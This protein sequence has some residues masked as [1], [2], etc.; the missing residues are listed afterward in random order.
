MDAKFFKSRQRSHGVTNDDLAKAIGRDRTVI[1]K[2][3]SGTRRMRA[4]EAQKIA[5]KLDIPL[6]D[7]LIRAGIFEDDG[8]ETHRLLGQGDAAP[9]DFADKDRVCPAAAALGSDR[10]GADIWTVKTTAMSLGG[11]YPG[12]L[13]IVDANRAESLK[14]GDVVIAHNYDY[15][16]NTM[17]PI[18]RR[19]HGPVLYAEADPSLGIAPQVLDNARVA[20]IGVVSA[21]FRRLD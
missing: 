9:Y 1:S 2:I 6:Q 13:L 8:R 5:W 21:Q 7:V 11:Y 3:Y 4:D 19:F 18:M 14:N 15:Q 16:N 17:Q 10:P 12:D 20:V